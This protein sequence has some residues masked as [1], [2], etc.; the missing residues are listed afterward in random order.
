[1]YIVI[2]NILYIL[3]FTFNNGQYLLNLLADS[4]FEYVLCR[5]GCDGILQRC[6]GAGDV[7]N[8]VC[9][10]NATSAPVLQRMKWMRERDTNPTANRN[11]SVWIWMIFSWNS[12]DIIA[13][14]ACQWCFFLH[15]H[16]MNKAKT[17]G[18]TFEGEDEITCVLFCSN[19][20]HGRWTI[21]YRNQCWMESTR[22]RTESIKG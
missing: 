6:G 3:S 15:S 14:L 4:M 13:F 18:W 5:I 16:G 8:V 2:Y 21:I 20:V 11:A 17:S 12:T 19:C 9:W 1:M 7:G 22:F 10:F